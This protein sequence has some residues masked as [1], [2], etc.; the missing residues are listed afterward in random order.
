MRDGTLDGVGGW[1][2]CRLFNDVRLTNAPDV[3]KRSH[4]PQVFLPLHEPVQ[5][6]AG[7]RINVTVM[8]RQEDGVISWVIELADSVQRFE[9]STFNAML[10]DDETLTSARA[11]RVARL[12]KHGR[13]RQVVLSYCDGKMTVAE[14]QDLVQQEHPDLFPSARAMPSFVARVLARDTSE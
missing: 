12:N 14:I 1:F 3:T 9:H 13:A 10:L 11:D 5:V 7:D 6:N 2:D 8:T 4:R